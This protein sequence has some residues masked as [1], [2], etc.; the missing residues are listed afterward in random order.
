[1]QASLK[2]VFSTV[3]LALLLVLLT[4][5]C[6][7]NE[8]DKYIDYTDSNIKYSDSEFVGTDACVACHKDEVDLWRGSHH[9]QAMKIADSTTILADFN[10]SKFF[11]QNV[12][13]TFFIK[14][15]DYFVNLESPNG[16]FQDYKIVYTFGVT[17]LQQ[18]IVEF[19]N[20]AYQCLQTAWDSVKGEWFDLQP[21]YTLRSDEWIHWSGGGMRWN[22]A[23]ADC[24]STNLKKNYTNE[25]S[26]FNTTFSEI[27][28]GCEACHGPSSL[29]VEF[30]NQEDYEG[31]TP[32]KMYMPKDMNSKEVVDK[33]A[34]C[35][36]RRS[37]LTAY[38]DYEGDFLDHYSPTLL[39]YPRYERDGQILD[40]DY[41]YG[42]FIQSKMYHT[43]IS[44]KD[45]HN[46]HSLELKQ[47]GNALCLNCHLPENY[48]TP[49]HHFHKENTEASQC[50]NCHMTGKY[51]MGNDFRRDHSFRV[52]RPD[53]S[54]A[55][56]TP[57]A[58]NGCHDD[59]D[60]KWASDFIIEKYGTERPDHFSNHLTK[61]SLGDREAL[62]TLFSDKK[63][64]EHARATAI[65]QYSESHLMTDEA[66]LGLLPYLQDES[67]IVRSQT[68]IAFERSRNVNYTDNIYP[69]LGDSHRIVRVAAARY[70][71]MNKIE[72]LDDENY[73]KAHQEY[74]DH[75]SINADFSGGQLQLALYHQA[76]NEIDLA[77]EAYEKS[78]S[79][80]VYF[81]HSKMN[82][83]F[84]YYQQGS[85]EDAEKLYLQVT[86]L[87]PDFGYSYYMLGLL[88]NERGD[89]ENAK[90]YL[91]AAS[92][93]EPANPNAYYNYCLILQG[94]GKNKESITELNK[95]LKQFPNNERL[96]YI[97]A[98]AFMN[99]K[100][101]GNAL[102]VCQQLLQI[103]P[104]NQ[105]YAQ[106]YQTILLRQQ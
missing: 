100:D 66:L 25:N 98:I 64:P 28:V 55:Y 27:N 7:D 48:E 34:R 20:G 84:I 40:E 105:N 36:S 56:G 104:N 50:I 78:I 91:K 35:H 54:L 94:E 106:L 92:T 67:V 102:S 47:T 29:H 10:N 23:C 42:S 33:C 17:P 82:L 62:V 4:V 49:E 39:N 103:S 61:G 1:M 79:M 19:P 76:K 46:M 18:Y 72:L 83:A 45:C 22:T 9:D 68:V 13:S 75:L 93:R 31:L 101:Y 21:N 37:Q 30:Y 3:F 63:Y 80:D 51:Y 6:K 59:K 52:P 74:V 65:D 99:L 14:D 11:N 96:L 5:R 71:H 95:G 81:N 16:E 57:N 41:V 87:E 58:C 77:I 53:Q 32:P 15:G 69:L 86:E 89:N 12:K 88:Y 85:I 60:A 97:K 44:C 90:K 43:G 8:K 2:Y 70:Y 24:H 38:F 26:T 73:K